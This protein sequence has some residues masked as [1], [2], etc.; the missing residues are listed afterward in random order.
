MASVIVL[1]TAGLLAG[2]AYLPGYFNRPPALEPLLNQYLNQHE[3]HTK[4]EI[5]KAM[6][7]AYNENQDKIHRKLQFFNAG[8]VGFGIGIILIGAAV[9]TQVIV[10]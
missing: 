9:I 5:V 8:F 10:S 1:L 7:E 4:H 6:L 2:L 3:R